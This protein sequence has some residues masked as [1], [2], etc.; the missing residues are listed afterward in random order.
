MG[1]EPA[2][3]VFSVRNH[4]CA[5]VYTLM[6]SSKRRGPITSP[7][8]GHVIGKLAKIKINRFYSHSKSAAKTHLKMPSKH[9]NISNTFYT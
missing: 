2:M 1:L 7:N 6:M 5:F 8:S 9:L 3:I 4:T